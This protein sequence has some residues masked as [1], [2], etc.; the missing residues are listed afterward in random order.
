MGP[1]ESAAEQRH[2]AVRDA[3]RWLD[4]NPGLD[5]RQ[6]GV[7]QIFATAGLNLLYSVGVDTPELTKAVDALVTAKDCAVRASLAA[8]GL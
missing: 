2:P 4:V 1:V 7:A 6:A 3:A 8:G 5:Q